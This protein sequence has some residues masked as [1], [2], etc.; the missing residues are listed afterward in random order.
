[1]QCLQAL[2]VMLYCLQEFEMPGIGSVG[3]FSGTRK[4]KEMFFS[5]TSK[6]K[7][8]NPSMLVSRCLQHPQLCAAI[9]LHLLLAA[10][11]Y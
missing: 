2:V 5:F 1:M 6:C 9:Y 3:G 10:V 8:A 11:P 4:N 7:R